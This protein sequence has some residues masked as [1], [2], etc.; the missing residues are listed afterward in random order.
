MREVNALHKA[1]VKQ[2]LI[3]VPL[4]Y[5]KPLI[6]VA[7]GLLDITQI[8]KTSYLE[9]FE[10]EVLGGNHRRE[11][12]MDILEDEEKRNLDCYK[13]VYVQVYAGK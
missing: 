4:P 1:V 5:S 9:N 11:A 12:L 13:Y 3:E 8:K 10:L 2:G 7:K 6:L